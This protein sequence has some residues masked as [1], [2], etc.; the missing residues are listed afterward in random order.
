ALFSGGEGLDGRVGTGFRINKLDVVTTNACF[1]PPRRGGS[2]LWF[3]RTGADVSP[4]QGRALLKIFTGLE[5][6]KDLP[7]CLFSGDE[8]R[9]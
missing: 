9:G 5:K 6:T 3:F 7:G 2:Y 1:C 4:L 8:Y